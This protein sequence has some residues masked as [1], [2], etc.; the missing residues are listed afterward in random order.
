M[1]SN[2]DR[3][4]VPADRLTTDVETFLKKLEV[5]PHISQE[6]RGRLLFGLDATASREPT[7]DQAC[8]IQAEMFAATVSLGGLEIQ[9]S[10]YR[11]YH[12]FVA[13]PW[14]TS[15][16]E[17]IHHMTRVRCLGGFTQIA[18]FL[19]NAIKERNIRKINAAVFVGDCVEEDVDLLSEKAGQIGLLGVPIFVFQEGSDRAASATFSHMARLTGG[20]HCYFNSSSAGQLQDLLRAVAIFAAGGRQALESHS[21]NGGEEIKLLASKLR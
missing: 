16:K 15:A 20:V 21:R 7:W 11:G 18:R 10:Y 8:Q 14:L 6:K 1:T 13:L 2:K 5:T 12:E 9:L 19:D 3:N 17:L 4:D